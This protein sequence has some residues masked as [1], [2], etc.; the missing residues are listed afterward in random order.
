MGIILNFHFL[1]A[2]IGTLGAVLA[3]EKERPRWRLTITV[4]ALNSPDTQSGKLMP[5]SLAPSVH[6]ALVPSAD[7][8]ALAAFPRAAV[9]T[10]M[11]IRR[12]ANRAGRA[13]PLRS[14]IAKLTRLSFRS[15]SRATATLARAGILIR[16]PRRGH[17][18]IFQFTRVVPTPAP[19][20]DP[21]AKNRPAAHDFQ[22]RHRPPWASRDRNPTPAP[23]LIDP[24]ERDRRATAVA[25]SNRRATEAAIARL[26]AVPIGPG[27]AISAKLA[28]MRLAARGRFSSS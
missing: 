16:I 11:A 14:T 3:P 4:W 18:T 9:L 21:Q 19:R 7:L 26:Q 8:D 12:H 1:L 5:E 24:A 28:T 13:W 17:S 2:W 20:T 22:T 15:I 25:E 23:V 27:G 10:Y 6:F